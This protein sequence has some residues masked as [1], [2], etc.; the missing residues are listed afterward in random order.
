MKKLIWLMVLGVIFFIGGQWLGLSLSEAK[1]EESPQTAQ[2]GSAS[3]VPAS[4]ETSGVSK[5]QNAAEKSD[6]DSKKT[7]FKKGD[8]AIAGS[9]KVNPKKADQ[10]LAGVH[11]ADPQSANVKPPQKAQRPP[12]EAPI[13]TT[14]KPIIS[15]RK[16]ALPDPAE[17]SKAQTKDVQEI[18]VPPKAE[19]IEELRTQ[20]TSGDGS[21]ANP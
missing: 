3:D 11:K 20:E 18:A 12:L 16:L 8:Q 21:G 10:M 6:T 4:T 5:S 9:D 19:G 7:D 2:N 13:V 1:R 17:A 15:K 14:T